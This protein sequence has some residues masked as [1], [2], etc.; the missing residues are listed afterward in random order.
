VRNHTLRTFGNLTQRMA[1]IMGRKSQVSVSFG[2]TMAYAGLLSNGQHHINLPAL[3]AGTI[4]SEHQYRVYNGYIDHEVA[5]LRWSD[6]KMLEKGG[7]RAPV[8]RHMINLVEDIRIENKQI[9]TYPGSRKFL[10][11]L[12]YYVDKEL[13]E[14]NTLPKDQAEK[15]L[16]LIYKEAYAKYREIDTNVV[17]DWLGDYSDLK[18]IEEYM[19]AQMPRLNTSKDTMRIA[20][21]IVDRLPKNVDWPE[22]SPPPQLGDGEGGI[23]Q[24]IMISAEGRRELKEKLKEALKALE[25]AA[26]DNDKHEDRKKVL[27]QLIE[28]IDDDNMKAMGKCDLPEQGPVLPPCGIHHDRVFVPS[29]TNM[30]AYENTR[31][32][33]TGEITAAKKMLSM[34][35][36]S[37]KNESWSRGLEEGD[38]DT[39]QLHNLVSLGSNK[40]MKE[41]R[42]RDF[43]NTAVLLLIDNSSSMHAGTT[44]TTAIILAEALNGIKWL[45]LD[46][47]GFATNYHDY[48]PLKDSG[49]TSGLDIF[50]YKDFDEPYVKARGRLGAIQT[51]GSTPLGEAYGHGLERLIRRKEERRVLWIISDGEPYLQLADRSHSEYELMRRN[52]AKCRRYGIET[53]GTYVG[54]RAR[55]A[56]KPYV[57]RFSGIEDIRQMPQSMMEIIKGLDALPSVES[58]APIRDHMPHQVA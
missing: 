28:K 35:L 1:Q 4:M 23:P 32:N 57:D 2:G 30:R 15:V 26:S 53:V 54:R 3:P 39:S 51:N 29:K 24:L 12:C 6:F 37:R 31:Q 33:C 52:H 45:K 17:D 46:I 22:L 16:G 20:K 27:V 55:G 9:D 11:A 18:K 48:A 19:A 43:M 5:H 41:R 56:L 47:A 44:R 42:S 49:R 10:D 14:S 25:E 38:L 34:Y 36:R 40:I 21:G 13:P 8:L 58:I 7:R 50:L